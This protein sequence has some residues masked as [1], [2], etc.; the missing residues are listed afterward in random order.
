MSVSRKKITVNIILISLFACGV[1]FLN[2]NGGIVKAGTDDVYKNIEVFVE[3]LR[4]VEENYVEPQ[5]PQELIHGAIKGM[6][7][8]L[9]P[10][11]SFM[12][13]DEYS[14]LML[15][16]KGSFSGIGI[17]ITLKDDILTVV[18]PIEG[19]PADKAGMKS[20]DMIIKIEDESTK[21]MTMMD[22]VKRI[23]G[24]K[25]SKVNLTVVREGEGKPLEFSITRD[26]IPLKSVRS[27]LLTPEI[28]YLRISTFQSKTTNDLS[29]ALEKL[30]KG[31]ITP[32]KATEMLKK[33][34]R[35]V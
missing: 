8:G 35:G 22:A 3:V 16:T 2:G 25:G 4:Q 33:I 24:P 20:G 28:G 26:V 5:D 30:E 7:R 6:V 23:R 19:T 14:E 12:T 29:S 18:S 21:D 1:L 17:E 10:H 31:E 32:S 11:S 27:Y 15:E 9:D 34:K 13:K